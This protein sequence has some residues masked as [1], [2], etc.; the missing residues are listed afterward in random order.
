MNA[1]DIKKLDKR[2][3]KIQ[4]PFGENYPIF[5]KLFIETAQQQNI[6]VGE[7]IRQ[8]TIWKCSKF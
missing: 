4:F 3:C 7:V 5:G 1:E 8:Y 6:P 2:I